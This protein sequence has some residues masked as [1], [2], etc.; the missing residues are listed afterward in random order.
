MLAVV[1]L[2][3]LR[4]KAFVVGEDLGT[5][6]EGVRETLQAHNILSYRVVW[7]ETEP[8]AAYPEMALAAVTTHDLPTIAGLWTGSDAAAQKSIGLK[9]NEAGMMKWRDRLKCM[10]GLPE[11]APIDEVIARTHELLAKAPSRIVTAALDDAL[12]VEERPNLPATV[13]EWPN[14]S[15]ALPRSLEE[16]TQEPLVRRIGDA[17]D[18]THDNK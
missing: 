10:C 2:E 1:A 4:A 8:P 13:D 6:E 9:P 18:R 7:F 16:I 11:H 3:S 14:W 5:L 12:A 17:L 15:I